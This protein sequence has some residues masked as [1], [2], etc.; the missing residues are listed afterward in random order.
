MSELLNEQY[1]SV[2]SNPYLAKTINYPKDFFG[3]PQTITL[4]D[5]NITGVDITDAIKTILQNSSGGPDEFPALLLKKCSKILSYP[6]QLHAACIKLHRR[7][8]KYH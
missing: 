1:N 8:E 3:H 6:L 4:S 2:F 7:Q 5:I